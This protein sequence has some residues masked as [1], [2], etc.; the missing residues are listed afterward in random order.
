MGNYEKNRG[1][2]ARE[3]AEVDK[4]FRQVSGGTSAS[5]KPTAKQIAARKKAARNRKIAIISVCSV[6]LVLLL[7]LIVS[8]IVSSVLN[9]D[10]GKILNN[11]WA[12]GV[13]LGGMT[14]DDA[15][16]ALHLATDN[17]FSKKDMVVK[18]P[19]A[20]FT[21]SPADTGAKLDV[22]AVVQAAFDYGRTGSEAAQKKAR[23]NAATTM[24]T[25]ALLPYLDLD[26]TVI[27]NTIQDFCSSYSST[28]TPYS[29]TLTGDRPAFDPEYPDL[30]AHHQTLV[31][32]MGTPD[33]ILDT[34]DLYDE[35]LDAYSLNELTVNYKAPAVTEPELPRAEA[36]FAEHCV[37]PV[38]ATIDDVTFDV[39]PEI[40]GYGFNIDAVQKQINEAEY[41][42]VIEVPLSFIMPDITAKMLTEDLFQDL[43]AEYTC[44]YSGN[45][46]G[47]NTN[48]QLSSEKLNGYVLKAGE[49]FSFNKVI[50]R[51]TAEKGYKKAP[52]YRSG[53][54]TDILG[55]GISQTASAL[56]YCVL[57]SDFDNV[58]RTN[59]GYAVDYAPLG[60]DASIS[61]GTEDLCFRNN[62]ENPVRIVAIADGGS[63]T[64]RIFGTENKNYDVVL[65]SE[66][67][68]KYDPEITYQV[69]DKNNVMG[70]ENGHVLTSG[71]TGYD[72]EVYM[73]RLHK[74]TGEL[75]SS[76][77]VSTSKYS[78]RDQ[79]V[80][81]IES[82]GPVIPDPGIPT[83]TPE[84]SSSFLEDILNGLF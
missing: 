70:Y 41:G 38:D 46:A 31:I 36:L 50:G 65:R 74:Q 69:M 13:N 66:T 60:L 52:G 5:K 18:L 68:A 58:K 39:T 24:H 30:P 72:V 63:V 29:A 62:T 42:E 15:K 78:K 47:W 1:S 56:Y 71:I 7:S 64:V 82:D 49:E 22:D 27:H 73:D 21:L 10:D 59:N 2:T 3:N 8:M 12:G 19:N 14:I 53:V 40:Y 28:M 80:V 6:V 75:I 23:E 67:V 55:A 20:S 4:A 83:E 45:H 16:N 33:Y 79:K 77:L 44:T 76:D 9:K 25:I 17:T 51:L 11:V 37:A 84:D 54:E 35:V 43:L 32:T 81:Y 61:W 57:L 26:L 34:S 48:V